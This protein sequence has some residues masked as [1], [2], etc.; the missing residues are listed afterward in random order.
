LVSWEGGLHIFFIPL[1]TD[2]VY[3]VIFWVIIFSFNVILYDH[4]AFLYGDDGRYHFLLIF[5]FHVNLDYHHSR[6]DR[7]ADEDGVFYSYVCHLYGHY[8]F[9]VSVNGDVL[10]LRFLFFPFRIIFFVSTLLF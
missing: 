4:I 2:D 9:K 7:Y 1:V 3:A 6:I 5:I 10:L 8:Y